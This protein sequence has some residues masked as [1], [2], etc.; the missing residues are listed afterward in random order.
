MNLDDLA[1]LMGKSRQQI[2]AMLDAE[3]VIEVTLKDKRQSTLKD[4]GK[5]EILN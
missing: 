3:D 2:Q 1:N 4:T 5:I